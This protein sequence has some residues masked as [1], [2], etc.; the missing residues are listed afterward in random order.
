VTISRTIG[1]LALASALLAGGAARAEEPVLD[2]IAA[3]VGS[4]IVLVSEVRNL[5]GPMERKMKEAGAPESEI[6]ALRQD[7][8]E[9]LIERALI[10]QVVRRAE[11][12][13]TDPEVDT[14]IATI[15]RENGLSQAQLVATVEAEGLP[16]DIY[17][18]RIRAEIEQSKV[19][20]GMVAAKVRIEEAELKASYHEAFEDQPRTGDELRLSHLLVPFKSGGGPD[21]R[22]AA[23]ATAQR[24]RDRLAKGDAFELVAQELTE[25]PPGSSDLGWLHEVR[26]AAWMSPQLTGAGPGTVTQVIETDFGCNVLVVVDRRPYVPKG[27]DEVRGALHDRLFAER[28]QKEYLKFM[29]KLREQTYIERKGVFAEAAPVGSGAGSGG[30][31]G[32]SSLNE[33][34]SGF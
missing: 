10:R 21:A 17:R 27:Y 25:A 3:Q 9:R 13:A 30:G 6:T 20:N 18:E 33:D 34:P 2:G 22:K 23:C 28:M 4:D 12:E 31:F 26:L 11:L 1:R 5:I 7:A 15:A 19:I 14:A 32:S 16:Y 29:D 24:G 8:L